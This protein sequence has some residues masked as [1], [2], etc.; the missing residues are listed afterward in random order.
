MSRCKTVRSI[1]KTDG[2]SLSLLSFHEIILTE[3]SDAQKM[4][5]ITKMDRFQA[6]LQTFIMSLGKP[7][8]CKTFGDFAN[9]FVTP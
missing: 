6:T 1:F 9:A 2:L 8:T 5:Q 3:N 4:M 7:Q